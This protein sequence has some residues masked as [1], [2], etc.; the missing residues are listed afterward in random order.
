MKI[1]LIGEYSR[2]HNSLKEGL[3]KLGH[4]VTLIGTGDGFKNYPVDIKVTSSFLSHPTLKFIAIVFDKLFRYNLV[5]LEYYFKSKSILKQLNRYDVIQLINENS[6]KAHPKDEIRL[7]KQLQK[8]SNNLHLLS[9]GTDYISVKYAN[10]NKFRYSIITPLKEDSTL[11]KKYKYILKYISPS[12]KQLHQFIY[13]HITGVSSS[14]MDYH[15][16][17]KQHPK[18]L[19]LIPNPINVELL[20]FTP[21]S[22]NDKI[23]IFH[24]VNLKNYIKKGNRF[25]DDAL[26][27][28]QRK[29]AAQVN[30]IRV[31]NIPYNHYITLYN[32]AHIL[33]DQVYAYDQGY[34]ALEAM[35]KGKVVF[36]G[37]EQEWL[38]YYNLEQ[39]TVA[40]NA[41]PNAEKIAEKLEYL[42]LHPEKII[43]ISKNARTFIEKEHDYINIAKQYIQCWTKK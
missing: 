2:L 11:K 36:T 39:D 27:I 37:A 22:I 19:G 33:L 30:I 35:A 23:H 25:F 4:D 3:I 20:P 13:K 32:K 15:I 12:Y 21:I 14:D 29:Y 42:I 10:D 40:I 16:P 24:G 26:E 1:L 43:E 6:F 7:I 41:L 17:L 5:E 18:Y 31:E 9:C 38:D 34:N 8:L 28:I